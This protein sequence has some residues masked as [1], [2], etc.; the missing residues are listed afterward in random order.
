MP[1]EPDY[2][3]RLI[4]AELDGLLA[5]LPAIALEGPKAVGKTATAERRAASVLALDRARTRAHVEADPEIILNEPTPLLIDEWNLVPAVWD[6]VR[7]AVDRDRSPGRFILAGSALPPEGARIHSGSGR[8]V[9]VMLRPMILPER[10]VEQPTVSL[11]G[12]LAGGRE[13][14]GGRTTVGLADYTREILLSGFPGIRQDPP[15]RIPLTLR[16][17][18]DELLD[19]D[20][21]DLG[22]HIRR[23]QALRAWLTAYAAATA[24]TASYTSIL[25]AATPG[26]SDKPAKSTVGA[27]RSLMERLW[28]VDP[29]PGWIPALNPLKRLSQSAKHHL[30]DP[31]LA[32][33]LLG[34]TEASLLRADREG[35]GLRE[36]TLL[37]ALF[38]S[39]VVMTV[40]VLAQ[41]SMAT[42]SQLRTSGGEHEVDLIV[43]RPDHR[44]LGIEVKLGGVTT[45]GDAKHLHWLGREIGDDLVD[46]V[47]VTTGEGAY[48]TPDGVAVVPLALLG[49]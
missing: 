26:E 15:R 25:D 34:A 11:A 28:I 17:Y 37:G 49:A 45:P 33:N 41:P 19:R 40:R 10:G 36:G 14:I 6:V 20:I 8:I 24:T 47:I 18:I 21:P 46:K 32:A 42:V 9:R 35:S 5:D 43:E 16:S 13:R 22:V 38:E 4:D 12:L 7:R 31:A 1:G 39:L 30:V 2:L 3:P 48:R 29:L 44:V 23:P 27:Y